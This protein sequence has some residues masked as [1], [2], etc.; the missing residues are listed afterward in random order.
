MSTVITEVQDV[1][2]AI[3][4]VSNIF[5]KSDAYSATAKYDLAFLG[6]IARDYLRK[7]DTN[8]FSDYI[9]R[10]LA[11][12][13]DLAMEFLECLLEVLDIETVDQLFPVTA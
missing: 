10:R 12:S 3:A 6:S 9:Q 8:G 11:S 7:D 4:T 5:A 13:P 1:I 2:D